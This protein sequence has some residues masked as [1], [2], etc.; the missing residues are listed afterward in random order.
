VQDVPSFTNGHFFSPFY[1]IIKRISQKVKSLVQ[2][3]AFSGQQIAVNA[4]EINFKIFFIHG[5]AFATH[6]P[7]WKFSLENKTPQ[8]GVGMPPDSRR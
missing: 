7:K 3:M 2:K 6:A 5:F 1:T 8:D 4:G